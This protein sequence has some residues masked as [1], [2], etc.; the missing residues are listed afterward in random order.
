MTSV[1]PRSG[2][3]LLL[4]SLWLLLQSSVAAQSAKARNVLFLISDDLNTVLS[5]YGAPGVRTPNIDRLAKR[6]VLFR[7][8]YCTF[9]LCGPSRNSL[10][11]G[12]Y[13]NSTGIHANSLIFRQSVPERI[14]LP[15]AFRQQG[16]M[17]GRIGKLYHYNVPNSIG[18]DGHDDPGSWEL[19]LNP[20]GVDRTKEHPLITSLVP[21]SF[22]GMLSWHASEN[23]DEQHT[24]ALL[25]DNADWVLER[26]AKRPERPFFLA[27]GFFR[28]HTPY[29]AP[30]RWFDL[31]PAADMPIVSGLEADLQ[32][33]PEAALQSQVKAQLSMTEQQKRE[34]RQAYLACI[35]FL[36]AQVGK[37]L[38]SLERHG[39]DKNTVIVFTSDHGYHL[40]EHSLW[41][42][43]SLF[44]ES[45]RVPLLICAPGCEQGQVCEAPVSHV[46][47][48]PTL[49][50]L[51]G[52]A[53]PT[54]LQGQSLVPML[55]DV[56]STGRNWAL[57][58][59]QRGDGG[60]A[61]KG[62][63]TVSDNRWYGYSLRTPRWRYT[64]WDGGRK[65]RELYDH[66]ND[67]Q[68]LTNLADKQPHAATVAE[69]SA[70][71][72]TAIAG[73]LPADGKIPEVQPGLWA[74]VLIDP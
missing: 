16:W 49:T 74:P 9:P 23:S 41:Q 5:C 27:V 42:K 60:A 12:L 44:E 73:S 39:L 69:L 62:R 46:D 58:Q 8:A 48:Y 72:Q 33:I 38:D 19:E 45:A 11:T 30:K 35:S 1:S 54:G 21:N 15:Q 26:C 24:D 3:W 51:C 61:A 17:A 22:G 31:Y 29:V 57:T 59:V 4:M 67:P 68:E 47:L 7:R 28:P 32:D 50:E 63:Q 25:A 66:S 13:P 71:L 14:S 36:D 37:V 64:E 6:S 40:G 10:L 65:G 18:T 2:S 55:Q 53:Q 43:R 20:A 70:L 56:R 34:A 52:V